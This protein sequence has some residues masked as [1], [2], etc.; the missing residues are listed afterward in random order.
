MDQT[1]QLVIM[2]LHINL[3]IIAGFYYFIQNKRAFL[4]KAFIQNKK[5]LPRKASTLFCDPTHA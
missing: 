3:V 5:S 1:Q 2:Y 4:Q